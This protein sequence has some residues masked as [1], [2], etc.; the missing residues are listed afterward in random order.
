MFKYMYA[1]MPADLKRQ[2]A[3]LREY[4]ENGKPAGEVVGDNYSRVL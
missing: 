1:D 2:M 4:L 3:E